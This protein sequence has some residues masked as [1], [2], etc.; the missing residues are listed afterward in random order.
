MELIDEREE[1]VLQEERSV[2]DK[3]DDELAELNE[4]IRQLMHASSSSKDSGYRKA[5]TQ[6][7]TR[8][9]RLLTELSNDATP[10]TNPSDAALVQ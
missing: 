7:L 4:R 9:E 8:I 10:L 2:L 6:K 5:I 3:H 1:E